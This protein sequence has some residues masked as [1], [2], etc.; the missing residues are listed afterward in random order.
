MS[1]TDLL[2]S[3]PETF[4]IRGWRA[5]DEAGVVS[6]DYGFDNGLE[7]CE[8]VNFGRSL[9]SS[10]SALR[11]PF[12][13]A[14]DALAAAMGASYYKAFVPKTLV[15]EGP[16][17]E[18]DQLAFF[19]KLY[20][21]GLAEFAYRNGLGDLRHIEFFSAGG[22]VR[23]AAHR[24]SSPLP[25]KSAVLIGGGKDSLVSVEVLRQAREDVVL[26]AVNP[27]KPIIDCVEA[28]GLPSIF[29]S[30]QLDK[31]L[32]DLNAKGALNGH[33]PI[34]AIV[35]LIA[36][37]AS[38][39]HGYNAVVLSNERSANEGNVTQ[40]DFEINHQYSKSIDFESDLRR[41][42]ASYIDGSLE[43]FSLLRPLS[44]FHIAQ[45]F[46]K[47]VRYDSCFTSCNRS[48]KLNQVGGPPPRWCCDCPKCR[49]TF[50][51]LATAMAPE[52]LTRIFGRDLLNESQQIEGY[53]ELTGL[54]GHKPWECVGELAES[55][56]ALILLAQRSEWTSHAVVKELAPRLQ[57]LL[58][59]P[60]PVLQSLI[61][62]SGRHHLPDR[63]KGML[64]AYLG[65]S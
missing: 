7:F 64:D 65:R 51:I 16:A 25:A 9:P 18:A 17:F 22:P 49:F 10:A 43:Y 30:R 12:E 54:S 33:V 26:F 58:P 42:I 34:T 20:V 41:Y 5:D 32:F 27:K 38:Y 2:P 61:T 63:F 1:A 8:Q 11:R 56:G 19:K 6:F 50:L 15:V 24:A 3:R 57:T 37:A 52:R 44:E 29:I 45:L 14:L 40:G 21:N 62:P 4:F 59:D 13:A 23:T 36:A 60:E 48:F 31:R 35:S 39:V 28:S 47:S 55:G 46:A 53:R